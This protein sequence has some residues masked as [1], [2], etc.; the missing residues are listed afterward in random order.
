MIAGHSLH[1]SRQVKNSHHMSNYT[2]ARMSIATMDIIHLLASSDNHGIAAI[3]P[4]A[5]QAMLFLVGVIS[6]MFWICTFKLNKT[7]NVLFFLL[8]VTVFLL[9]AGVRNEEVDRI[10]GW[11]GMATSACAY[12]L[13]FAELINDIHGEG[14][15]EIIPLG[16]FKKGEFQHG[17]MHTQSRI[18]PAGPRRH[19]FT[20]AMDKFSRRNVVEPPQTTTVKVEPLPETSEELLDT[21]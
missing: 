21:V 17:G 10:A 8:S 2:N 12:W 18:Q 4:K 1:L 14:K 3:N 13:A 15:V 7:I 19:M 11:F 9:M 5:V 6:I 16:H 20:S